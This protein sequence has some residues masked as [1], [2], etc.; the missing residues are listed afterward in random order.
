MMHEP[1]L[2][3]HAI[4]K[5]STYIRSNHYFPLDILTGHGIVYGKIRVGKSFFSLILIQEALA[6]GAE[7][8]VF[9]PH[10][11][12]ANRLKPHDLLKTVSTRGKAD[13]T[14]EL[15]EIYQEASSW[16]RN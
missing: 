10:G 7:V 16:D 14:E 11:T 8:I 12:L 2:F 15:E 4:R 6:N 1:L 3:S 5:K 9:D 13:I